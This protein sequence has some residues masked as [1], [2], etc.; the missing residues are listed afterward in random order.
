MNTLERKYTADGKSFNVTLTGG[1]GSGTA[2]PMGGIAGIGR[3]AAMMQG[4]SGEG[5][6]FRIDGRTASLLTKN[7]RSE[8]TVF[9]ESGS[10]LKFESRNEDSEATLKKMAEAINI[11]DLDNYLKG[12]S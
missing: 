10:I 11:N 7:N 9:P 12:T 8:L 1:S 2:N 4:N 5:D 3:M 6:T